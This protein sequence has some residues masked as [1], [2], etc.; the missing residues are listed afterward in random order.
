[1][2]LIPSI[3]QDRFSNTSC[4][5]TITASQ[6]D[7]YSPNLDS[8]SSFHVT[9][10]DIHKDK[11]ENN[12]TDLQPTPLSDWTITPKSIFIHPDSALVKKKNRSSKKRSV[13]FHESVMKCTMLD[14]PLTSDEKAQAWYTAKD[15][16]AMRKYYFSYGN[17]IA[18][19]DSH[20]DLLQNEIENSDM[21]MDNPND[22]DAIRDDEMLCFRGMEMFISGRR[23]A[24]AAIRRR[25]L[26]DNIMSEQHQQMKKYHT[27]R[28]PERIREASL[29]I[30]KK[31]SK[32]AHRI[33]LRSYCY[34]LQS[35]Q[36]IES[37][38]IHNKNVVDPE[39]NYFSAIEECT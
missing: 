39:G 21:D 28:Y 2:I 17:L 4:H 30:S 15:L 7:L 8:S 32:F 24:S 35:Q 6:S 3:T 13:T 1:M 16:V 33:A 36:R 11:D 29:S 9:E 38:N 10:K 26:T 12:D 20:D 5:L 34:L 19:L 23:L 25:M 14:E 22:S 27:I 31:G 18:S 37:N